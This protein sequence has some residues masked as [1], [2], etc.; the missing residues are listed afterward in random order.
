[1]RKQTD[2]HEEA[3]V[4]NGLRSSRTVAAS[5]VAIGIAVGL[6]WW[7]GAT[8]ARAVAPRP[9]A[10]PAAR[11]QQAPAARPPRNPQRNAY[12]G[13]L[14][15]HTAWSLDAYTGINKVNGPDVAYRYGRGETINGEKLRI[16]L[17]FMAVTDHDSFL[18]DL[19]TC[20]DPA[21]PAYNRPL[22]KD[23]REGR[24][25]EFMTTM[26]LDYTD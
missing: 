5:V 25:G 13:D 14:H 16:P 8:E 19:A 6:A 1:M 3:P 26:N 15:V 4:R 24:T 10:R 9:A 17:D 11:A 23:I 21:D 2:S 18:G 20:T 22:C 7:L 12:F